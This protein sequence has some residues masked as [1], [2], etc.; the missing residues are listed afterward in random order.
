MSKI[1]LGVIGAM[2]ATGYAYFFLVVKPLQ[3]QNQELVSENTAF[4]VAMQEQAETIRRIEEN[5]EKT[6]ESLNKLTKQN[7][8]YEQEQAEYLDI[9]R[10][11]N[12]AQL[13]SA[14]PG[15][16]EK[17]VNKG[18]QEVFDAIEADSQRISNLSN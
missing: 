7:Q 6:K 16:V 12:L 18:T 5:I 4:Q 11:H 10:R 17:R 14:K 2:A 15:L 13:A 1:L 8:Q 9:F 3:V